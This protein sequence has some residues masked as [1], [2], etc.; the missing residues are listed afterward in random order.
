MT[1]TT[2]RL[3]TFTKMPLALA[4][5]ASVSAPAS[6]FQFDLGEE[7]AASLNTTLTAGA[8]WRV[9][10]REKY[11]LG[12]GN[13]YANPAQ[14]FANPDGA[15]SSINNDDGNWNFDKGDTYSEI[16]KG[17]TEFKVDGDGYGLFTR[18]RYWYDFKLKRNNFDKDNVGK[19]R[20]LTKEGK[21]NASGGEIL[22]AY[23]WK[24]FD[25][26]EMP[27]N[28]RVGKQVVSWGESTFIFNGINVINPVDLTAIRAPGAE[29]KD[30]LLPVNMVY[31]SLGLT[32]NL[33]LEAFVQ[34]DYEHTRID[35]CG[36]FFSN[37][38]YVADGCGPVI[39]ASKG[40]STFG[41][42]L[43]T[44][45]QLLN[46]FGP[47]MGSI[48]NGGGASTLPA[49]Y[50]AS[51]V[52]RDEALERRLYP[53]GEDQY[54]VALRLYAPDLNETE[55][56]FYFVQYHN[57][58]PTISGNNANYLAAL[59]AP[60][61]LSPL[62]GVSTSLAMLDPN[63]RPS[64][65]REYAKRIKM[66]GVSFN[67]TGPLGFSI[68]GEYSLKRDVPLQAN[69][70]DSLLGGL[71][72]AHS[73]L[74][75][76]KVDDV[77]GIPGVNMA[78]DG[79][80]TIFDAMFSPNFNGSFI[81]N[82]RYDVSQLQFTGIKFWDQILGASR[83]AFVGEVG[84]TYVHDLADESEM[85]YGRYA[86]LGFGTTVRD[87]VD[88]SYLPDS[89]FTGPLAGINLT[90]QQ[91]CEVKWNF[92]RAGCTTEGYTTEFS[93]GYRLKTELTYS[94]AFAGVSLHPGLFWSHDVAGN[95]PEPGGNF[96]EGRKAIGLSLRGDYLNTYSAELSYTNYFGG[97]KGSNYL[98]DKD[99]VSLSVSYAF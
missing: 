1:K 80:V 50:N 96:I 64:Y 23:I 3:R 83:L 33:T 48:I 76:Y 90:P 75:D 70:F 25:L 51:A 69:A 66:Y 56:G 79:Q 39:V 15:G 54:G 24:D 37:V 44:E 55:F 71:G 78:P 20:E 89:A 65:A 34:L 47:T 60:A 7:M 73:P 16:I 57:R 31:G 87:V 6:A 29:L 74:F 94:D 42:T 92:N 28:M 10:E 17:V 21:A 67:T 52:Y 97:L 99:N 59:G 14:A 53:D 22:D 77:V 91:A 72:A 18:A 30:A 9:A 41:G 85:R 81:S 62:R 46:D 35:D 2:Q 40:Y 82:D 11:L 32:D 43:V 27:L 63:Y 93:W 68:G 88:E 58:F 4:V 86:Q 61:A 12:A 13:Y 98:V 38:D 5:A 19:Q 26:G 95:A 45:D 8:S 49:S 36:T 84:F